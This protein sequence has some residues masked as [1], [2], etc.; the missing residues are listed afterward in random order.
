MKH[1]QIPPEQFTAK[2]QQ[3]IE[4]VVVKRL[5]YNLLRILHITGAL[6]ANDARGCFDRMTLPVS[7]MCIRQMGAPKSVLMTLYTT[8][9][10]MHHYVRTGH[11]E[12]SS[13]YTN[14]EHQYLQGGGQGNGSGPPTWICISIVLL[15]IIN[16]FA[17]NA[18]FTAA[19]S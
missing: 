16:A 13:F 6:I 15:S 17:I 5:F 8:T 10:K 4:A 9:A 7:S 11:G 19:I 2:G 18:A 3:G 12:S 1:N 14:P